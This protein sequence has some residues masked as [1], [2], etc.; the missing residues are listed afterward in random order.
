M[1]HT[2][3]VIVYT[4]GKVA[5]TS[6]S[7]ALINSGVD[8]LDVHFLAPE[9]INNLASR[10][11]GPEA[12]GPMPPHLVRSRK[13]LEILD[14]EKQVNM[15]SLVREPVMRMVSNIF[16]KWPRNNRAQC[17]VETVRAELVRHRPFVMDR[18]FIT[19]FNA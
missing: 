8:C 13:A 2:Q 17:N 15:I 4:M 18:W 3:P 16:Q 14:G 10:Y 19:V 12:I 7:T 11:E 6:I 5:S 1:T 9:N